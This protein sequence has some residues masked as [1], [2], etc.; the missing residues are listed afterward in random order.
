MKGNYL[1]LAFKLR[2]QKRQYL[3]APKKIADL[4]FK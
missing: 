3:T 4:V 2:I 1:S